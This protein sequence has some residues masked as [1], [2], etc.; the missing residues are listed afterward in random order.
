MSQSAPTTR[1]AIS[2]PA[3]VSTFGYHRISSLSDRRSTH[4]L[5]GRSHLCQGSGLNWGQKAD[6]TNDSVLE[7]HTIIHH[8]EPTELPFAH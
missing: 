8:I 3:P 6:R 5:P 4:I 1:K 2:S 7:F